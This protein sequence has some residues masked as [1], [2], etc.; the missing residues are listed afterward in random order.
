MIYQRLES[1]PF[2]WKFEDL[3]KLPIYMKEEIYK[4]LD[5][6]IEE[7]KKQMQKMKSDGF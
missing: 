4:V 2:P 5:E 3:L 1:I 7:E 6:F